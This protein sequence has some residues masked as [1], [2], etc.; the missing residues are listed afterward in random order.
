MLEECGDRDPSGARVGALM[1]AILAREPSGRMPTLRAWLP[2]GW[3]P[4]QLSLVAETPASEIMM[5]RP[6]R[7]D[8]LERPLQKA[9]ARYW[10]GD[11]F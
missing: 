10:H 5:V 1:Q 2:P 8:V 9:D 3:L 6:L 11:A 7:H 4:P